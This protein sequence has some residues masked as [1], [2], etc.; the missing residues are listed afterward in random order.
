MHRLSKKTKN[1]Y[2][3]GLKKYIYQREEKYLTHAYG[4]GRM[5]V[6]KGVSELE[7]ITHHHNLLVELEKLGFELD[8]EQKI[9]RASEY[10][11]ECLAPFEVKLS[12]Y[13]TVIDE[14]E[15]KNEQLEEEIE[16][17]REA[18]AELI[19][20]K[21]Y[22]QSL[23]ENAQDI[24][25][26][27]DHSGII[28]YS[29]PSIERI[30]G[31]KHGELIGRD[32]FQY[33][34][35]NDVEEVKGLFENVISIPG[36]VETA[37][38]RFKHKS[39]GW[40]YLES[41]A[42]NVEDSLDGPI[43]IVNSRDITKRKQTVKRLE[44]H[45]VQLA[46]AQKI[47][48]VGS[49]TWF[50]DTNEVR[51]SD[52]M[53]RIYGYDPDAFDNK[54]APFANHLHPEDRPLMVNR[55]EKALEEKS[56]FAVEHRI[57]R[58]DGKER[59]LLG[60]GKVITDEDDEIVKMIG[61]GQDITEQKRTEQQLRD[62]S[63][64][65]RNL[66]AKIENAREEERIRISRQVHDELGQMLT[67]L[68]MDVSMLRG[69]IENE[70]SDE[71]LEYFNQQASKV[72]DRIN[73]IIKSVQRITTELRP[74][75]LDDLGLEEAIDW[76]AS[77][78]EKRTDININFNSQINQNNFLDDDKATTLFRIFQETLTNVARHAEASQVEIELTK[79]DGNLY[80]V[81]SDDGVGI[82]E[83]QKNASS[84]LGIIGMRERTQFLGGDVS[85]EGADG[86]GTTVTLQLPLNRDH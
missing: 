40:V 39:E 42:K 25:T 58:S 70:V 50:P 6:Q 74:E 72:L 1:R 8:Y 78:F 35:E 67:V 24:I 80:L 60:R 22:F 3:E 37:E 19:R 41:I 48:H 29:S 10:L 45:K 28:R 26:V 11:K 17:R 2:F 12:S 59:I 81:I 18:Q 73:V 9:K 27:L 5:A 20:N 32:A 7:L 23:I 75:V 77:E 52:E 55:I 49:W 63:N 71:I 33:V 64:R 46:D 13:R 51:W 38:F 43:V 15:K 47:A 65:L 82:T 61:T 16:N 53:A 34:H 83:E 69:E 36:R 30:L 84:S 76:Q 21:E 44:E 56:S 62:Y 68:K 57:I 85:I 66:S 14:L 4:M 54:Y 79:Q 86:K 31:Y